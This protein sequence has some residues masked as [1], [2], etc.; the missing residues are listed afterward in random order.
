MK[1]NHESVKNAVVS[2]FTRILTRNATACRGSERT[3]GLEEREVN[4]RRMNEWNCELQVQVAEENMLKR[5][6]P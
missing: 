4:A 5:S 2:V 6:V 3:S 1:T